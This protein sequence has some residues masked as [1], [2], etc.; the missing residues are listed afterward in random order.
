MSF[1][2]YKRLNLFG[3]LGFNIGS[4]R[5]SLSY[6]GQ[7][8]SISSRGFTLRTGIPGLT[9]FKSSRSKSYSIVDFFVDIIGKS[10]LFFCILM[11]LFF[12]YEKLVGPFF[13]WCAF[14]YLLSFLRIF[15]EPYSVLGNIIIFIALVVFLIFSLIVGI[16]KFIISLFWKS[17]T[18]KDI[19]ETSKQAQVNNEVTLVDK[20]PVDYRLESDR[21]S[22]GPFGTRF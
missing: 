20:Q 5:S 17:E 3:G 2:F 22:F 6:R 9:Y 18:F 21:K 10:V 11:F 8:G 13:Y 4:T 7:G 14:S 12:F 16:L 15:G 19:D 1:R